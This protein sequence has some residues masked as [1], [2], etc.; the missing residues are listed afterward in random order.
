MRDTGSIY[1][2]KPKIFSISDNTPD[3]YPCSFKHDQKQWVLSKVYLFTHNTYYLPTFLKLSWLYS[4]YVI[5]C[6]YVP[7]WFIFPKTDVYS[8]FTKYT[9]TDSFVS[10]K[11]SVRSVEP[12]S[13]LQ[14]VDWIT[15]L[16]QVHTTTPRQNQESKVFNHF[17]CQ[18]L[19]VRE[20]GNCPLKVGTLV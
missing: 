6:L 17:N 13:V 18:M 16:K 9:H 15:Q 19:H 8:K 5:I 11:Q 20:N 2:S 14:P 12:P 10:V 4:I 3:Q 7:T 1:N